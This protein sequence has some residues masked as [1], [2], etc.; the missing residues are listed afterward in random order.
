[1]GSII[2]DIGT[3]TE[4]PAWG[5]F[6]EAKILGGFCCAKRD[7]PGEKVSQNSDNIHIS[8]MTFATN[9]L[10]EVLT[11]IAWHRIISLISGLLVISNIG[12]RLVRY[13]SI[14]SQ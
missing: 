14:I 13:T 1:M 2:F 4:I 11:A 12:L 6:R 5:R 10:P 9:S 8:I 7:P 3:A